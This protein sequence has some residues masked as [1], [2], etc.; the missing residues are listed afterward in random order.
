MRTVFDPTDPGSHAY[1]LLTSIVVPRPIAW[2]STLDAD[3]VGNLAPHSFFTVVSAHP[4]MVSFTSVGRKDTVR[5]VVATGHFVVNLVTEDLAEL[6]NASSAPFAPEVDEAQT[7][8]VRLEP[9]AVVPV[10]R[11]ADSPASIECTLHST[12]ALGDA[13]L[14][15]GE[16]RAITVDDSTLVDGFPTI[17]A[18]RPVSRLGRDEWGHSPE[19]FRLQRPRRP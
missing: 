3:G 10:P 11:V 14:V 13:H 19:V 8:G 15:V 12:L 16:V 2:I 5:N 18:L 6:A 4:A 9:S 17:E 7:L 1:G